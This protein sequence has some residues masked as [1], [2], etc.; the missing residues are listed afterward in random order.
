MQVPNI[1]FQGKFVRFRGSI[2]KFTQIHL[3][4]LGARIR[5]FQEKTAFFGG[6]E[7][8]WVTLPIWSSMV[9]HQAGCFRVVNQTIGFPQAEALEK[10]R[11]DFVL[12]HA[13][14]NSSSSW[15]YGPSNDSCWASKFFFGFGKF[16]LFRVQWSWLIIDVRVFSKFKTS[17][18]VGRHIPVA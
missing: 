5:C 6:E 14:G 10:L 16:A 4:P 15:S 13:H 8:I 17:K 1:D 9:F 7:W 12:L 18:F 11:K 3:I 2:I